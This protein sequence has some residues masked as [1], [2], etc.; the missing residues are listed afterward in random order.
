MSEP[1]IVHAATGT[2]LS[3][4]GWQQEAAY[5]M[6]QNNLDPDVAEKP[7]ELI[8]YGGMGKAARNWDCFDAILASLKNLDHDESLLIQS[9]EAGWYI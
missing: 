8:V 4:K 2:H 7:D 5:R 3:C 6:I 9:G 1:R